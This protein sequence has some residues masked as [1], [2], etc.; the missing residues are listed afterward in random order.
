MEAGLRSPHAFVLRRCQISL[1]TLDLLAQVSDEQGLSPQVVIGQTI[2]AT[3]LRLGVRW[4]RATHWT[5]SL[6]P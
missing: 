5:T 6:D 4:K 1:W 2:R 3:R